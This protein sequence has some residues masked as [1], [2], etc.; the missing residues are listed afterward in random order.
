MRIQQHQSML[1]TTRIPEFEGIGM[2]RFQKF[3]ALRV[4]R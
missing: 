2:H 4:G 3:Q 1:T